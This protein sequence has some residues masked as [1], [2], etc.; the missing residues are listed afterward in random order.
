MVYSYVFYILYLIKFRY[1][2]NYK[3]KLITYF[4]S[5]ILKNN[6]RKKNENLL[7]L[8]NLKH[9]CL[10]YYGHKHVCKGADV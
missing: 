2:Q 4:F 9:L 10:F 3:S 8:Y 7:K 1:K 5:L 6:N